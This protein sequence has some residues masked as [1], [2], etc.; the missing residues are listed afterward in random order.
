MDRYRRAVSLEST[1]RSPHRRAR[2]GPARSFTDEPTTLPACP[3]VNA[4]W[5]VVL[6]ERGDAHSYPRRRRGMSNDPAID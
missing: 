4:D 6:G 1:R 3:F 2:T 5:Q